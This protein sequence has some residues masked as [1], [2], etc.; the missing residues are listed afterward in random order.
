VRTLD[1]FQVECKVNHHRMLAVC[2]RQ[3]GSYGEGGEGDNAQGLGLL[4]LNFVDSH[5]FWTRLLCLIPIYYVSLGTMLLGVN[6][7]GR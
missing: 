5:L 7:T 1:L 2:G 6:R 3:F 4:S